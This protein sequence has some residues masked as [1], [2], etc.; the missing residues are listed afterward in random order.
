MVVEYVEYRLG[1]THYPKLH[2]LDYFLNNL[3]DY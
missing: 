1:Y 2:L 3:Y